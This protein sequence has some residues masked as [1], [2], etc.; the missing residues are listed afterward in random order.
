MGKIVVR[1]PNTGMPYV[2]GIAGDAPTEAEQSRID[3]FLS[4][5]ST[6]PAAMA[7]APV[8]PPE[9]TGGGIIGFGKD[10]GRGF[11]STFANVPAGIGALGEVAFGK[12]VG[13]TDIGRSLAT[14][15]ETGRQRVT[16]LFGE[17]DG[18]LTSNTGEALGS[19]IG[20]LVPAAGVA[21]G[22]SLVGAGLKGAQIAGG[23]TASGMGAALGAQDQLARIEQALARGE[24]VSDDQ[25]RKAVLIGGGIGLTEGI[26]VEMILGS[27]VRFLGKVPKQARDEAIRT[28]A[29]RLKNA[30]VNAL[31]EGGQ[32][33]FAGIAQDLTEKGIYNPNIEVGQSALDDLAAGGAAGGAISFLLDSMRGRQLVNM[34]RKDRQIEED[35]ARRAAEADEQVQIGRAAIVDEEGNIRR[36]EALDRWRV[37]A[38]EAAQRAEADLQARASR[39]AEARKFTE[40]K[41]SETSAYAQR[42]TQAEDAARRAELAVAAARGRTEAAVAGNKAASA[43]RLIERDANTRVNA[44]AMAEAARQR[45]E[46]F[47]KEIEQEQRVTLAARREQSRLADIEDRI[48]RA[49]L[50]RE[51]DPAELARQDALKRMRLE[52]AAVRNPNVI[53]PGGKEEGIDRAAQDIAAEE[54]MQP[55]APDAE[56]QKPVARQTPAKPPTFEQV[57]QQLPLT[58]GGSP[59]VTGKL[60]PAIETVV[61]ER[62]PWGRLTADQKRQVADR[63]GIKYS[64]A[65]PAQ[66]QPEA[67]MAQAEPVAPP[68]SSYEQYRNAF[69]PEYQAKRTQAANAMRQFISKIVPSGNVDLVAERVLAP[70]LLMAENPELVEGYESRGSDGKRV[71]ALAMDIY[72]PAMSQEE[73]EAK[74]REVI[75][76]ELIH[77]L[78]GLGLFTDREWQSLVRAAG[79]TKF[80]ARI[81]GKPVQRD[82]TFMEREIAKQSR[83]GATRVQS[84]EALQEEAVAEMFRAHLDGRMKL[85]GQPAGLLR[86][87]MNFLKGIVG[88]NRSAGFTKADQIFQRIEEGEIGARTPAQNR[89]GGRASSFIS[90]TFNTE[91]LQF[92]SQL[93]R[94][95]W[96]AKQRTASPAEWKAIISKMP[97]IKKTEIQWSGVNEWLDQKASDGVKTISREDVGRHVMEMTPRLVE[98]EKK[99]IPFEEK[100]ELER[101]NTQHF[102]AR[103]DPSAR[104][105]IDPL[106]EYYDGVPRHETYVEEGGNN[107]REILIAD[108]ELTKRGPNANRAVDDFVASGHFNESNVLVHMRINDRTDIDGNPVLFIE[109]V[110]SDLGSKLRDQKEADPRVEE[111]RQRLEALQAERMNAAMQKRNAV[112]ALSLKFEAIHGYGRSPDWSYT[113]YVERASDVVGVPIEDSMAWARDYIRQIEEDADGNYRP[114]PEIMPETGFGSNYPEAYFYKMILEDEE[115]RKIAETA[116]RADEEETEIARK[117]DG[118]YQDMPDDIYVALRNKKPALP[119]MPFIDNA[120]YELAAK[121]MLREAALGNYEKLAWTPGYMQAERWGREFGQRVDRIFWLQDFDQKLVHIDVKIGDRQKRAVVLKVNKDGVV[122]KDTNTDIGATGKSLSELIGRDNAERIMSSDS[123]EMTPQDM[124]FGKSGFSN[125]YDSAIRKAVE[126]ITKPFG[127][128]P[129]LDRGIVG[130]DN[131]TRLAQEHIALRFREKTIIDFAID[132]KIIPADEVQEIINMQEDRAKEE[133]A[134]VE[135][136]LAKYEKIIEKHGYGALTAIDTLK[137]DQSKSFKERHGFNE[138]ARRFANAEIYRVIRDDPLLLSKV[139]NAISGGNVPTGKPVWSVRITPDLRRKLKEDTLPLYSAVPT[140]ESSDE[141]TGDGRRVDQGRS[142]APLAGAPQIRGA[143]GPD[144]GIVDV[145]EAY[146]RARGINLRRQAFYAKADPERGKRIAAAFDAMK[147]APDDPFVREAYADMARQTMDQYR[148]LTD[149]GYSFYFFDESNDPYAGNPWNAVRDLRNNKTMA[150]FATEA[151]YGTLSTSPGFDDN[152]LTQDTGI[153][154]P[155]GSKNGQ[156]KRVLVNDLFRAVHD[157]FG[158]SMEGAGFRADG[159]E[160][161]WQAHVRLF[162]GPAIGA[163]TTE[164]RG[165]NSWLNFGPYAARNRTARVEDTV[166]ADQ[167]IG[168]MPD[169]T[170]KDGRVPDMKFSAVAANS[171]TRNINDVIDRRDRRLNYSIAYDKLSKALKLVPMVE[172]DKAERASQWFITQFQDRMV[173][174]GK[175]IDRLRAQGLEVSDVMDTYRKEQLYHGHLGAETRRADRDLYNPLIAAVKAVKVHMNNWR[176]LEQVSGFAKA[177][178]EAYKSHSLAAAEAYLYARHAQERNG[179][180]NSINPQDAVGSGMTKGEADAIMRWFATQDAVLQRD[181]KRVAERVDAVIRDTNR[182]RREAGLIGEFDDP[183]NSYIPLRGK[184]DPSSDE[185]IPASAGMARARPLFGATG[186]ED[187]RMLGRDGVY[188]ADIIANTMAQNTQTIQRAERNKVGRSLVELLRAHGSAIPEMRI[189]AYDNGQPRTPVTRGIGS[190]GMVQMVPEDYRSRRDKYLVVKEDGRPVVIEFSDP[191]IAQAMN[192]SITPASQN[193]LIRGMSYVNRLLANLNTSW[194]P[195]FMFSNFPRDVATALYNVGQYEMDGIRTEVAKNVFPALMG[196]RDAL[197]KDG[198]SEWAR[199]FEEFVDAGG[200]NSL[201]TMDNLSSHIGNLEAQLKEVSDESAN[202]NVVAVKNFLVGKGRSLFTLLE[203]YNTVVENGMRVALFKALRDRGVS[204]DRAAQA[205]RDVTTNFAKGGELKVPLN[206]A[207]LFFNASLQGSMAIF[208]ATIRNPKK[209]A[210]TLA[211]IV[212]FGALMDM[213]NAALSDEDDDGRLVYDK[214]SNYTLEHNLII[215]IRGFSDRSY[216][217]IP[218]PYGLNMFFNWGRALSR[219]SRGTYD[220]EGLVN[221]LYGSVLET[222][223]PFGDNYNPFTGEGSLETMIAPTIADPFFQIANNEDFADRPIYKETGQFGI[224]APQSHQFWASTNPNIVATTQ[225]LNSITG[226]TNVISGA[227]DLNPDKVEFWLDYVTGATG[228]FFLRTASLPF[229]THQ[230]LTDNITDDMINGIPFGRKLMISVTEREDV[231]AYAEKRDRVLIAQKELKEAMSSRDQER[232]RY[233]RERYALELRIAPTINKLNSLRNKLRQRRAMVE[234]DT[235][236]TDA[237]KRR[238]IDDIDTRLNEIVARANKLM[239]DV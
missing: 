33:L 215:P 139:I 165:Q 113:R 222:V 56:T 122:T 181:I 166:F 118:V 187:P 102:I 228:Q 11:A 149:A 111:Y 61:G 126:K 224:S 198:K 53:L 145:A 6:P 128:I 52:Q 41:T 98:Y 50:G 80:V 51:T 77:A 89:G 79:E 30:G 19:L 195:E 156:L 236:L 91:N 232:V 47:G 88:A 100:Q 225:W 10:I 3:S 94:D 83:L 152:P 209:M 183:F 231:G 130:A 29:G 105:N 143:T 153:K 235:R 189:V 31:A 58:E 147:H 146:A 179:Y 16:G 218:L 97:G 134:D 220:S 162:Q 54:V 12:P 159:E 57:R 206:A 171:A 14:M 174:I 69:T 71:I 32:E 182:R 90:G 43:R 219:M 28:I 169:W 99:T 184:L 213:L 37:Q 63:L 180:I 84:M 226:G 196:I 141:Q 85:K 20:F 205:A 73:Y 5:V 18:D 121:R 7:P 172:A 132:A 188:A 93:A 234:K 68:R 8:A 49:N 67:S 175:I 214:L 138:L 233:A 237:Q 35:I 15:S 178:A 9:D 140:G 75:G 117:I 155:Y 4:S 161:A 173:P 109:E 208:N 70:E 212:A 197:R 168:L 131:L 164:T 120:Y 45:A 216:L 204:L 21:K 194:N 42:A 59:D 115:A 101:M 38:P 211:K 1:D 210:P 86:R 167:K 114:L 25:I 24:R 129:E 60:L 108:P 72:D 39:D 92:H 64:A 221:T 150:V 199:V 116:Y 22:A 158:H 34:E 81:D 142:L 96:S 66:P 107:Y 223:N 238:I 106:L 176:Q 87:I 230:A 186:R 191:R 137:Y 185:D 217:R 192:G 227:I 44:N 136:L 110:Q 202:G 144:K 48:R 74:L 36:A 148:A 76:H 157:A 203:D 177:A 160:N 124:T 40:Q 170:W 229:L 23:L 95:L 27:A 163:M 200:Q 207:Y 103:R 65:I 55:A 46:R 125:A 127:V 62:K 123:G 154:W 112:D 17:G 239:K 104:T 78:R 82:Y 193:S 135:N 119:Q 190:S 13:S 2:I 151:G 201:N 133:L 26:P